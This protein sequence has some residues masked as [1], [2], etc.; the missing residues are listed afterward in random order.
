MKRSED[1]NWR[2]GVG[3]P[4]LVLAKAI[5]ETIFYKNCM[6]KIHPKRRWTIGEMV[7]I[8]VVHRLYDLTMALKWFEKHPKPFGL[9]LGILTAPPSFISA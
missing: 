5:A 2:K 3:I 1:H 9:R 7:E 4:S 8:I 6:E